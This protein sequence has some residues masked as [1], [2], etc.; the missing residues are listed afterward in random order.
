MRSATSNTTFPERG[1]SDR[2]GLALAAGER[3]DTAAQAVDRGDLQL[4]HARTGVILHLRLREHL[5]RP[6][7]H[8]RPAELP[9]EVEVRDGVEVVAQR[10]VL[11]DGLDAEPVGPGTRRM[12]FGAVRAGGDGHAST[13]PDELRRCIGAPPP[14]PRFGY[15]LRLRSSATYVCGPARRPMQL[16]GATIGP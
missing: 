15:R 13:A 14:P 3:A 7:R 1:A 16:R 10:K 9:P 5:H 11:V 4:A 8:C 2:D 6:G 12:A